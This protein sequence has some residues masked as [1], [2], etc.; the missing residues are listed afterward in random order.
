MEKRPL[1]TRTGISSIS[2]SSPITGGSSG[3]G[4]AAAIQLAASGAAVAIASLPA[5]AC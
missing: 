3:I 2:A 1:C 4:R 5:E